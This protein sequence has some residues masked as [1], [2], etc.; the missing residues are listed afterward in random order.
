MAFRSAKEKAGYG[1][2]ALEWL[3][4]EAFRGK[5]SLRSRLIDLASRSNP[6][7]TCRRKVGHVCGS[8]QD[9][10]FSSIAC[11]SLKIGDRPQPAPFLILR[12]DISCLR[13][14]SNHL[15]NPVVYGLGWGEEMCAPLLVI[16]GVRNLVEISLIR[17]R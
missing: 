2:E 15:Q 3:C 4:V 5:G 9:S 7:P 10:S 11:H 17:G 1:L 6:S 16:G 14:D 13:F 12:F 8:R